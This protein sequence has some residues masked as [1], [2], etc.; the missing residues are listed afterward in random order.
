MDAQHFRRRAAQARELAK[1]GDDVRLANML[2]D[3]ASD[4]DAE[5]DAIE[6]KEP[7]STLSPVLGGDDHRGLRASRQ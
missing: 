1:S 6:A 3:V 7:R 5:A 4:M 2:L